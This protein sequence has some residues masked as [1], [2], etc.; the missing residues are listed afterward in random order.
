MPRE[1]R[2]AGSGRECSGEPGIRWCWLHVITS[3]RLLLLPRGRWRAPT[4]LPS[5]K[6]KP[7]S[8]LTSEQGATHQ[9]E[10][11][12]DETVLDVALAQG[13][14]VPYDCKMGVCL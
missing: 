6:P 14:D 4:A 2:A 12:E 3:G 13:V 5:C 1:G 11:S 8:A 7:L 10:V 9:L